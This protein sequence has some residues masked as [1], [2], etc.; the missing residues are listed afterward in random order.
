MTHM[1]QTGRLIIN[2]FIR[3]LKTLNLEL[4]Y[5]NKSPFSVADGCWQI[6]EKAIRIKEDLL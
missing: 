3:K 1:K 6:N 4:F 5:V 2:K